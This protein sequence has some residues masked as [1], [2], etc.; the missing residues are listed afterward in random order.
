VV[1]TAGVAALF[2]VDQP[3]QE[4]WEDNQSGFLD[5]VSDV[6]KRFKDPEVY[7]VAGPGVM[8][9]GLMLDNP[10]VAQTGLQALTAYGLSSGMM[11]ATKR[12]FGR[13]RPSGTPDDHTNFDWFGGG[14]SSAFPSG[15]A[16]VVF[17]LATTL[18]DA[19]DNT[20]VSVALYSGAVLNSWSRVYTE[21]HWFTDVAVGAL[22]GVA[23]AKLVNGRW[24]VFGLKPPT[25]IVG[26]EGRT[27]L[28][29]RIDF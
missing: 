18:S 2:L 1:A 9:V 3:V 5:D 7:W 22:Y 23:A 29:Y 6:A 12:V 13:S 8:A 26:P 25:V 28:L 14:E 10:M 15:S 24:R 17:S 4:F 21:R 20:A 11:I 16:A 27:S 19:I